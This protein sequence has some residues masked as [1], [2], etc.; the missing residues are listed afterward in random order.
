MH[1]TLRT[2]PV[3][4]TMTVMHVV[5]SGSSGC[6]RYATRRI[7]P[8]MPARYVRR[9]LTFRGQRDLT[10]VEEQQSVRPASQGSEIM[11]CAERLASMG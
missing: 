5:C 1:V 9:A 7:D 6:Q 11:I 8:L 2:L 10:T 3:K 4:T